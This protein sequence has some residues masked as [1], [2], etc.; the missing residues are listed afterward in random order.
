MSKIFR[1]P[2]AVIEIFILMFF[3]FLIKNYRFSNY[4]IAGIKTEIIFQANDLKK[5]IFLYKHLLFSD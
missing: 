5:Y 3:F 4:T 1:S 2:R